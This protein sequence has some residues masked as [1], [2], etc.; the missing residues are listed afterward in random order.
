MDSKQDY[1]QIMG[2][3]ANASAKEIKTAYRRLARKYHPDLNKAPNAEAQFKALGEAY[4]VL[5]DPQKRKAYDERSRQPEAHF[6]E[7]EQHSYSSDGF[8]ESWFES[9]FGQNGAR[10]RRAYPGSDRQGTLT[11]TLEEAY[12]GVVKTLR[13]AT[14]DIKVT[15]PAGIR[16]G[17]AIR[18]AG[19]GSPGIGAGGAGDLYLTIEIAPH[20]LFDVLGD[21]V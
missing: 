1:Y 5:K 14:S 13:I 3:K 21:D 9:L 4:E 17:Q 19:L 20:P 12:R 2:L 10:A 8:D 15:V 7:K 6:A 16:A 18:L 11:I